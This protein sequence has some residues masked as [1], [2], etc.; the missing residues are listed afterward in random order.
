MCSRGTMGYPFLVGEIDYFLKTGDR[1]PAPTV[2]ERLECAREHLQALWEYKG[3]RGVR[4][5]RKHMTWYAKGFPGAA[6]LR[7]QLC[8]IE[9]VQQGLDLID[10][11]IIQLLDQPE[12]LASGAE[13]AL[14]AGV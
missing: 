12:E 10:Q 2:I 11:V 1:K 9:N 3:D 14:F 4:Q 6:E 8:L 5:A 7:G 13:I